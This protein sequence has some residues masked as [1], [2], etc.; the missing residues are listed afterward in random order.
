MHI[1]TACQIAELAS[2]INPAP[3]NLDI[4][5]VLAPPIAPADIIFISVKN[6]KTKAKLASG[7]FPNCETK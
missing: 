4:D 6:G 5:E 7:P 3:K 1:R 2:S